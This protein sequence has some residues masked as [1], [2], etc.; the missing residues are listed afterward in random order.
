MAYQYD[1]DPYK[2]IKHH[3]FNIFV[4]IL[5]LIGMYKLLKIELPNFPWPF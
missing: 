4:L 2:K 3:L 1:N 5:F